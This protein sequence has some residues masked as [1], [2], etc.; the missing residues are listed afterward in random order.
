M[1]EISLIEQLRAATNS[2]MVESA[3]RHMSLYP[4]G[5][6]QMVDYQMMWDPDAARIGKGGKKLR[7]L[8]LL[9]TSHILGADL[10]RVLPAAAAI[11][12][13]HNFSLIHDDIQD[14]STSR[15]GR[16]T[17][18]KKWGEAQ[19]INTGD[20]M[21]ALANLEMHQLV[22][23]YNENIALR[24]SLLLHQATFGLT[25]GQYLDL[26]FEKS[27][28]VTLNDYWK[29]ITG[30]TG[31][32]FAASFGIGAVLGGEGEEEIQEYQKLGF[33]FGSAFQVQD[34]YLG[35]WGEDQVTGKPSQND[36]L[37]RKKTFPVLYALENIPEFR[38]YWT[39]H[40]EFNEDDIDELKSILNNF[41]C[42]DAVKHKY[43]ELYQAMIEQFT[44]S[45]SD[46]TKSTDLKDLIES[47]FQREL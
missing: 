25:G 45:F 36:L 10:R 9:L 19:A 42:M 40:K 41:G 27:E 15:H 6:R 37:N 31:A 18:W 29:M 30:K 13:I 34:D 16:E 32:L 33:R 1:T 24:V 22:G 43:G 20:A 2:A 12:F 46:S 38:M 3:D 26:A 4:P 47:L 21:L 23:L 8:I 14:Q 7:P 5:F 11:E 39:T 35:I 17:V 44:Q 28:D